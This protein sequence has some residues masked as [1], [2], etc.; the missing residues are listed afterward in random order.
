MPNRWGVASIRNKYGSITRLPFD[1]YPASTHEPN[2]LTFILTRLMVCIL[3]PQFIDW[4][5]KRPLAARFRTLKLNNL[6][7]NFLVYTGLNKS[8]CT[9]E[10]TNI[11]LF[12]KRCF[13]Y[14]KV[15]GCAEFETKGVGKI[16]FSL[17]PWTDFHL[18]YIQIF[19]VT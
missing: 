18:S 3:N 15:I 10:D 5:P 16:L 19:I 1:S 8:I 6:H 9:Q 17:N 12:I 2:T 14:V 7:K 4:S 13:K 11:R